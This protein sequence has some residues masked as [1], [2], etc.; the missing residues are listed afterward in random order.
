MRALPGD[1]EATGQIGIAGDTAS[2]LFYKSVELLLADSEQR[3][4]RF[5]AFGSDCHVRYIA[6]ETGVMSIEM[7]TACQKKD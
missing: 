7:L 1:V 6:M 5:A 4:Q 3:R 2:E